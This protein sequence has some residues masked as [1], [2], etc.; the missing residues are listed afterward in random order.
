M[1]K[2]VNKQ[3]IEISN[4]GNDYF[5]KVLFFVRPECSALPQHKLESGAHS[6]MEQLQALS[7]GPYGGYL[8]RSQKRKRR[9]LCLCGAG[10]FC[11]CA[12]VVALLLLL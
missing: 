8:R 12:A 5:E 11:F 4:T 1:L 3:I 6:Y 2:G 7:S 9:L 10:L